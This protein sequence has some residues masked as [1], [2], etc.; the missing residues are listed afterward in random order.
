M[1]KKDFP[2]MNKG[3]FFAPPRNEK[4]DNEKVQGF[5]E[6]PKMAKTF[7]QFFKKIHAVRPKRQQGVS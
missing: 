5:C 2:E 4:M 3:S 6:E 7:L 1:N